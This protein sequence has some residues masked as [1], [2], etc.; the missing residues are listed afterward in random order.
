MKLLSKTKWVSSFYKLILTLFICFSVNTAWAV[1]QVTYYHHDALGSPIAA[2]D[3]NGNLLW[4]EAYRPYGDRLLKQDNDTNDTWFTGKQEDDGAGLNYFG[5]RWYDPTIGRF[6]GI[7]PI[8]FKEGNIHSFGRYTYA[9][10]NPY[11]YIDPDGA[12]SISTHKTV[13]GNVYTNLGF[14]RPNKLAKILGYMPGVSAILSVRNASSMTNSLNAGDSVK[15]DAVASAI[16]SSAASIASFLKPLSETGKSAKNIFTT[17]DLV[18]TTSHL[19]LDGSNDA[20]TDAGWK[21]MKEANGYDDPRFMLEMFR[22]YDK[23][24]GTSYYNQE[25]NLNGRIRSLQ[26]KGKDG[27]RVMHDMIRDARKNIE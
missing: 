27:V 18:V 4:R 20:T 15:K 17:A 9:N 3:E 26:F 11:I 14:N 24:Y 25:K 12:Y 8:G 10:N 5:A 6:M 16:L 7:D 1:E 19:L 13:S 21:N 23:K 2:T 22:L